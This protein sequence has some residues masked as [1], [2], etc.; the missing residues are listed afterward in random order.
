MALKPLDCQI[1]TFALMLETCSPF[2]ECLD[3]TPRNTES[4]LHETLA[5]ALATS[6]RI[7]GESLAPQGML[8]RSGLLR[9]DHHPN[10]LGLELMD[11]LRGALLA[12]NRSEKDLLRH[13]LAPA[14]DP[15]L[16]P[17]HYPHVRK[18]VDIIQRLLAGL[19]RP[20]FVGGQNS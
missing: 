18:D 15:A 20:G 10:G 6:P 7:I 19:N 12:E 11:N 13:F 1:L 9:L 3:M 17:E 5:I 16:A 8:R 14:P 4:Q 2:R